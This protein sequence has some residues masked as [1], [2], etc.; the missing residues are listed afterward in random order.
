MPAS[1]GSFALAALAIAAVAAAP[2]SV[3]A[4]TSVPLDTEATVSGVPVACTGVGESKLNPHWD[5]Y[6]VRVEFSGADNGLLTDEALT[7]FD[8]AGAEVVSVAC[9]GPWILL[10]LPPGS[11][12][13][14]G[15]LPKTQAMPQSGYF[16][17]TPDGPVHLELRFPD[18]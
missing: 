12:R 16:R 4:P 6:P 15:R 7:I 10:K 1:P 2:A 8:Q 14:E 3:A 17:V 9:A 18:T 11:Y 5:S 13:I